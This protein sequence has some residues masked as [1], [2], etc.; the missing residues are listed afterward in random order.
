MR[1][2]RWRSGFPHCSASGH[3]LPIG[4]KPFVDDG[5]TFAKRAG[6]PAIT[7]GPNGKGAHTLNE[8]VPIAELE[9]TALVYA[10]TALAYCDG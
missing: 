4:A 5:N 2:E 1:W 9:R 3:P 8:E 10:L 7:H 6:V